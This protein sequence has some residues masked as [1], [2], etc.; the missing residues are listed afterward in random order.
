MA[1][2]NTTFPVTTWI[3]DALLRITLCAQ[4]WPVVLGFYCCAIRHHDQKASGVERHLLSLYFHITVHHK[5]K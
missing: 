4:R 3:H 5:R 1:Y 2:I